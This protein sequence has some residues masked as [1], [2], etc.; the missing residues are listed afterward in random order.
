MGGP[1]WGGVPSGPSPPPGVAL[2]GLWAASGAICRCPRSSS[3]GYSL[4]LML[5]RVLRSLLFGDFGRSEGSLWEP[6]TSKHKKNVCFYCFHKALR[7]APDG[8]E[9]L[10]RGLGGLSGSVPGASLLP[11]ISQELSRTPKRPPDGPQGHPWE[12][13]GILWEPQ[14]RRRDPSEMSQGPPRSTRGPPRNPSAP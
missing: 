7:D 5:R 3:G 10:P 2:G 6:R 14:E 8:Q 1:A 11:R 12:A 13:I 9:T 4:V